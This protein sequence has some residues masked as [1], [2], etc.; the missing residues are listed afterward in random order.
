MCTNISQN[1]SYIVQMSLYILKLRDDA[2]NLS[3]AIIWVS[4]EG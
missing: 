3:I 4:S 1:I 2:P